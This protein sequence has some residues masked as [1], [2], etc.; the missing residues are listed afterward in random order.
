MVDERE[1][2]VF[3]DEED[4]KDLSLASRVLDTGDFSKQE[5]HVQEIVNSKG[6]LCWDFPS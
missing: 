2:L 3:L 1:L 6:D 5:E 4:Q